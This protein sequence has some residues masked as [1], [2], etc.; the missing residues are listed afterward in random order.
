MGR[1]TAY[2]HIGLAHAGGDFLAAALTE[3]ADALHHRGVRVPATTAEQM[4]RAAIEIRRDH[5][6]TGL[7]RREVEGTWAGIC[8]QA[9]KGK[10]DVLL[11]GEHL[12]ACTPP[13]IDLLL[14]TLPGF[15]VQ[16][17]VT[18][19]DPGSQVLASWAA[20]VDAGKTVSFARYARRV[21]DAAGEHDQAQRFWAGQDLAAVLARWTTA[22]GSP[23]RVH[24]VVTDREADDPRTSVWAAVGRIVGFDPAELPLGAAPSVRPYVPESVLLATPAHPAALP[25]ELVAELVEVGDGWRKQLA[26][27]GYDVHGDSA[28]LLPAAA[29]PDGMLPDGVPLDDRLSTATEALANLLVEVTRLREQC[30]TLEQRNATLERKRKK[31]KLRLAS[32]EA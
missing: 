11:S 20:A 27:G 32:A 18:A 29:A 19:S 1:R 21:M 16:L 2:L 31:L 4:H 14:D 23:D 7:P 12:A 15:D 10:R 6:A 28:L 22:I 24:V 30:R 26:D 13:Q 5:R 3:H 8:R 17:V 9:R 25:A